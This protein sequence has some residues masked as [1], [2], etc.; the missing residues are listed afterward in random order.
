MSH[1]MKEPCEHCPFRYD[2]KPFLHPERGAELARHAYNPYNSFTCHKTTV[3]DEEIGGEGTEMIRTA[4]SKECAGFLTLQIN[5]GAK[6]P[7]GFVESDKVY[8]CADDMIN[9]YE[10]ADEY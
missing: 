8:G 1:I 7:K 9:A 10:E 6:C 2:V 5:E 3:S 4:K